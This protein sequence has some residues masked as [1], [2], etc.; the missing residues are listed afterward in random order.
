MW[1]LETVAVLET[2]RRAPLSTLRDFV[3]AVGRLGGFRPTRKPL[4]PGEKC[5]WMRLRQLQA[6]MR[7]FQ[8]AKENMR[9]AKLK[10]CAEWGGG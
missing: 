4:L 5:L 7:A 3:P 1:I 2:V 10:A 9:Q 8:A 6:I